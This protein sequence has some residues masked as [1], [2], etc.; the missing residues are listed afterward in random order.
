MNDITAAKCVNEI[1]ENTAEVINSDK[2]V[3]VA[4]K[5]MKEECDLFIKKNFLRNDSPTEINNF[6]RMNKK[7][8][9]EPISK[10]EMARQ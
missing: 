8:K 10:N 7:V 6:R 3:L 1:K 5:M 9:I 2:G 4:R